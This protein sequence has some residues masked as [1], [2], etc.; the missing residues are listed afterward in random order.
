MAGARGITVPTLGLAAE[1]GRE[2][3]K[4]AVGR[5]RRFVE[6]VRLARRNGL[7]PWTDLDFGTDPSRSS[8]RREQ[9]EGLRSALEEAGG[10]FV[11][12]GQLLSTRSDLL[13][14]EWVSALSALQRDVEPAPWPEVRAELEASFS[15]PLERVFSSF[16]EVPVAAASIGQVHRARLHDG[17]LVAVKVLRPG[18]T[19]EVRR[20]VDVALRAVRLI[21]RASPQARQLGMRA[22]AEQYGADLIRQLDFRLEALN[23]Q[24]LRAVQARS[25][26]SDEL[27]L[28]E[29]VEELSDHRVLVMD[30]VEGETITS[31]TAR[32]G[33]SPRVLEPAL[34]SVLRA[35][36]RQVVL[37][38]VYHSDLHP[39][40]ILLLPDGRPALVDFGSVGRLDR[41]LR[42]RAQDL[43]IAYLQSD[44][45]A[46]ADA[47]LGVASLEEGADEDAFRRELSAFLT[48]ELGPGAR[49]DVATVDALVKV[50]TAYGLAVP[51]EVVAAGR[52]AAVLEGTLRTSVPQIDLLD[53]AKALA[54]EQ[55]RDRLAPTALRETLAGEALAL[56]PGLRRLPRRL[57]RIGAAVED[58]ELTVNIRVLADSRT[59]RLVAAAV[60]QA[61]LVAVGAVGGV[62]ALG[63]LTSPG[64]GGGVLDP[65]TV[66]TWLG[67]GSLVA[68]AAAAVDVVRS[69][70]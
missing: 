56:L 47:L 45:R 31:V 22:I 12:L 51:A 13:P 54:A 2:P 37:D 10:A 29:L 19:P 59:R 16:E 49:V 52:G 48:L 55:I 68:L 30:F 34:R 23:L 5:G 15:G 36:V 46:F 61:L 18:I 60:R 4:P 11:K 24:A 35:F 62:T 41:E 21:E 70:R 17:R 63:Y 67:A 69:R 28:P 64:S 9:A 44:N 32:G 25:P 39:G 57:E 6:L 58:G 65:A 1:R 40:N 27:V 7:L 42:E 20:D 26:R 14:E 43:L 3:A 50:V 8:L 53:E 33:E 38:G 66:G